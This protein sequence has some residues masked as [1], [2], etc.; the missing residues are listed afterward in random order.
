MDTTPVPATA[1]PTTRLGADFHRFW[2]AGTLTNLGDG[3]LSTALPLIAATLTHDPLA[4]S[5]LLVARFLPWLLVAP[6]AGVLIDRVDRLRAMAVANALAAVVVASLAVTV[7]TSTVTLGVMYAALFAVT[8]C[9]TVTD[10]ASRIA[11]TRLVPSRLLDRA[12]SRL[13]GGRLVAQD[14]VARPLGGALFAV[15]AV[16]PVAGTA[17]SYALCAV[18]TVLVVVS[19]RRSGRGGT[20]RAEPVRGAAVGA[21]RQLR[22]GCAYVLGD[23]LMRSLAFNNAAMMIGLQMGTAVLVLHVRQEWGVG[24][25]YF[26]LFTSSLAVGGVLGAVCAARLVAR[27]GRRAVLL[28]GYTV[29]GLALALMA[30]VPDAYLGAMVWAV[31]GACLAL[32]NI[33]GSLLFQ[34]MVPDHLRGRASAAFRA[35]GWGLAPVGALTGGLIGRVDLSLPYLVGGLT[36]VGAAVVFRRALTEFA[37]RS[38]AAAADLAAD[39]APR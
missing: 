1:R 13:E 37:H 23:P 36:M 28:G 6:F 19:L 25:A 2:A 21:G 32:T 10:P 7:A 24:A 20:G 5:G 11:V 17:V 18:L 16:L 29:G 33:A 9:E 12:N 35:L 15:A 14:C 27:I 4:V 26:G 30:L 38:D 3:I 8:C 31:V 34:T 22:E 39:A